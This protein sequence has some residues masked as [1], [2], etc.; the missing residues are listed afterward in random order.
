MTA[1]LGRYRMQDV[2]G[3][4]SF[5]TVHR[6]ADELLEDTVVVK[7][8]AENHSLNPEIR[9]RFIAEGRSLRKVASRHVVTVHDIGE[10][11][12]QQPYLVLEYADRGSLAERVH[13]LRSRGWRA[14]AQDVLSVARPLAAALDAVHRAQLVHR[15][16]S[17]GNLL[18]TSDYGAEGYDEDV[19]VP[20]LAPATELVT[21]DERLLVADLGMCK[22]L[23]LNSGLTVSGGTSGFRPPEQSGPGL[24]DTRADIWAASALLAWLTEGSAL[25][26]AFTRALRHGMQT[27]PERRPQTITAWLAEI[28][29]ALRPAPPE[30]SSPPQSATGAVPEEQAGSPA[31]GSGRRWRLMSIVA[32]ALAVLA[33]VIGVVIGVSLGG[34]DA[35]VAEADGASIA[36]SGPQEVHVGEVVTLTAETDGVD[37]WAW[38]LPTGR[39]VAD[40]TETT[41]TATSAGDTV[42][43]LR[44]RVPGGP[45]LETRHH[46]RVVE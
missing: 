19:P 31:R 4:G 9:E 21:S 6:A 13:T 38:S 29:D 20:G 10:S 3:V 36:I 44:A 5:A 27:K 16:L 15:D 26:G 22:D 14:S 25:P 43:V 41:L 17:P 45:E 33:L 12:R 35:P 11:A 18:L 24:V 39:S 40:E 34:D 46:I 42:V 1:E 8:L 32:G 28:E 30:P 23:A 2:V 7:I 37:S